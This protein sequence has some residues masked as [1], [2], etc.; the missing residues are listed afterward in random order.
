MKPYSEF[1]AEELAMEGLFI[2]WILSP[3][4]TSIGSF[5]EKWLTRHP[6]MTPTVNEAKNLVEM[7]SRWDGVVLPVDENVS[8]WGRIKNSIGQLSDHEPAAFPGEE[9]Q[10][11]NPTNFLIIIAILFLLS[12]ISYS[13]FKGLVHLTDLPVRAR[14]SQVSP[15]QEA[16]ASVL[17]TSA[18]LSDG[19][20]H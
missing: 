10:I 19:A 1:S 4:D 14:H 5:W 20:I 3:N 13:L 12:I 15:T 2:R 11:K 6:Q 18:E 8:L 7:A 17:C 16:P 9:V